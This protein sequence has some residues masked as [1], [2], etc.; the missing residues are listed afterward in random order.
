[1]LARILMEQAIEMRASSQPDH[2]LT[3]TLMIGLCWWWA[4]V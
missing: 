1:M 4:D 3:M 2:L